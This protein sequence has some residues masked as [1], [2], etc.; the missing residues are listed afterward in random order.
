MRSSNGI[1][2]VNEPTPVP[3]GRI[4][5]WFAIGNAIHNTKST[6]IVMVEELV[7][8]AQLGET[9]VLRDDIQHM[10]DPREFADRDRGRTMG[11]TADGGHGA[12]SGLGIHRRDDSP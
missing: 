2:G 3:L 5:F 11:T 8:L 12:M 9:T 7:D 1:T 4:A 6:L 10:I